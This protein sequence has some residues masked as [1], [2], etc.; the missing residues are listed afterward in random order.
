MTD[1]GP[2]GAGVT[3]SGRTGVS[4]RTATSRGAAR[5]VAV[6]VVLLMAT[7]AAAG[8]GTLPAGAVPSGAASPQ[9]S[10]P[11]P[12]TA[13]SRWEPAYAGAPWFEPGQPYGENFPDPEVVWDGSRYWAYSTSTGGPMLPA[14]WSTDL[15]TWYARDAYSPNTYNSDPFFN[16]AFPVPPR[17]S[18]GGTARTKGKAQWAPGVARI[19]GAWRAYTAWE[20]SPGRRCISAATSASPA[21]PFVDKAAAPLVCDA[22]PAGSIDAEPFVDADGRPWLLWKAEADG[23]MP[24][25]IY[26]RALSPDG[27]SFRPGSSPALLLTSVL[28][29][30]GMV[31]ENPSMVQRDGSYWLLYSGNQWDSADYRLG[32]ARCAGPA[33]PCERSSAEPLFS[34]TDSE[35]GPGGGSFFVDAESR[36]RI[37]YHA[38]NAPYSSYPADPN[39]DGPGLCRSEGQRFLHVEGAAVSGG[40]LTVD[41]VGRLDVAAPGPRTVDVAGWALDPSDPEPIAVHVY[42]DGTGVALTASGAGSG[43][44]AASPAHGGHA[45]AAT[46]RAAPGRHTV[47]AYGINTGAGGNSVLG[48]RSVVVPGGDPFGSLDVVAPA[49]GGV[50]VAGW[51]IDPDTAGPIAVHV[52]VDGSGSALT[53]SAT[54]GDVG[55]AYPGYGSGHGF[56]A[57]LRAAPGRHTVCAYGI[58]TG[59]GGNSVLGCRSV[60]VS[61]GDPFGSLDVVAPAA[62]GV[63]V[64]GWAIDPDTAGPIAVH[65][66]VDGSGSALTASATRGDV[67]AAYPGYG[68][69][70]GFAATLRAAPGRHTVCAYGINTGTGGNRLLRCQVVTVR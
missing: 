19:G 25:R 54:R 28:D 47:C 53:A 4:G 64:A 6:L 16:D 70:H 10:G 60:V 46:L 13:Y 52:Y 55:A 5:V 40:S 20:V 68:S 65:V 34:S 9:S 51:A 50:A 33:G 62:G 30:E 56:A 24:A 66:Y 31:V 14:M 3:A 63:A 69:G 21:G 7:A 32:Q 38:W 59:A 45:F 1:G 27:L 37:A 18:L 26:S 67:G 41:P 2:S 29:W 36:L 57:T 49:A 43:A 58:N 44:G 11:Q 48:C 35:L 15:G 23:G 12:V 17:W 42:V 61:G 8:A 39:C 22:G